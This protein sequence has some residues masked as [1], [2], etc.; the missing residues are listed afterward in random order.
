MGC[1]GGKNVYSVV[2]GGCGG[3]EEHCGRMNSFDKL[4]EGVLAIVLGMVGFR[5]L[6]MRLVCRRWKKCVIL[7][8]LLE[9]P[10]GCSSECA[11]RIIEGV[12]VSCVQRLVFENC[13]IGEMGWLSR[14]I[15]LRDLSLRGCLWGKGGGGG[16]DVMRQIGGIVGL[17]RLDLSFSGVTDKGIGI[18]SEMSGLKN[19]RWLNLSDCEVTGM[20]LDRFVNLNCLVAKR[21]EKIS[22]KHLVK[23]VNLEELDLDGSLVRRKNVSFI[24]RL[25]AL[26]KVNLSNNE[27]LSGFCGW[28]SLK[29]LDEVIL[30]N[31]VFGKDDYVFLVNFEVRKMD[32]FGSVRWPIFECWDF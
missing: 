11:N 3:C 15:G 12:L 13:Y 28:N 32:C 25:V 24:D 19:L 8:R 6:G 9:M 4:P 20:Y 5:D 31:C 27:E 29:N 16:G 30:R 18:M 7:Q 17:E 10:S 14:M 22:R 23:M 2:V 26:R 21:S 1:S